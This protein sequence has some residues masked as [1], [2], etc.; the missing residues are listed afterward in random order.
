MNSKIENT[1][2]KYLIILV[3]KFLL[4]ISDDKISNYHGIA[5]TM[6]EWYCDNSR[7][8]DCISCVFMI[9]Q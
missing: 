5:S 4:H 7:S 6:I 1:H 8:I 9:T 2:D 3:Y